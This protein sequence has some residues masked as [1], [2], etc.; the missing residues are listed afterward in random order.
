MTRVGVRPSGRLSAWSTTFAKA[1][2]MSTSG[3]RSISPSTR[4]GITI[5]ALRC[6]QGKTPGTLLPELVSTLHQ[7]DPSLGVS[8]E[9]TMNEKIDGTPAALSAPV[10]G[11]AGGRV[12]CGGAG[13]ERGWAVWSDRLLGEPADA[14]DWRA[15]GARG[16]ARIGVPDDSARGWMADRCGLGGWVGVFTGGGDDDAYTAVW[17]AAVGC[18]DAGGGGAGPGSVRADGELRSGATCG[19]GESSGGAAGGV[20]IVTLCL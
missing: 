14:G 16:A 5:S 3:R 19:F 15:D 8:D 10:V 7:I 1:R 20:G 2:L 9:A 6:A 12:C 13:V 4:R 18:V 11:V 17:R